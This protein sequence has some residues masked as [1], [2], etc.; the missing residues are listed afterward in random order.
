LNVGPKSESTPIIFR[1]SRFL[2]SRDSMLGFFECQERP[3]WICGAPVVSNFRLFVS[4]FRLFCSTTLFCCFEGECMKFQTLLLWGIVCRA[5]LSPI[6]DTHLGDEGMVTE[7]PRKKGKRY[8]NCTPSESRLHE[9]ILLLSV[10]NS[11]QL[12]EVFLYRSIFW[13]NWIAEGLFLRLLFIFIF[14]SVSYFSFQDMLG[15]VIHH[16]WWKEYFSSTPGSYRYTNTIELLP[17]FG[18]WPSPLG[19]PHLTQIE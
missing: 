13:F 6:F 5:L 8:L 2:A 7:R 12:Q 18:L 3:L 9:P 10:F 16:F 17:R 1:Q 4:N 14:L 19:D 15:L 11:V